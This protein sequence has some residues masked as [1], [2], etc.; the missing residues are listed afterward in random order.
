MNSHVKVFS[1]AISF[2]SSL[3]IFAVPLSLFLLR[4]SPN[5]STASPSVWESPSTVT[6]TVGSAFATR[7]CKDR[8]ASLP[9]FAVTMT[10]VLTLSAAF[11][12]VPESVPSAESSRPSGSLLSASTANVNSPRSAAFS[13]QS[14]RSISVMGVL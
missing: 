6:S 5:L 3:T 13:T 14:L 4:V 9:F 11:A 10:M 1:P 8:Y 12:G 2:F 7:N